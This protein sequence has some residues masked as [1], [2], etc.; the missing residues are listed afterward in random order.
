VEAVPVAD[1]EPEMILHRSAEHLAFGIVEAERE[2]VVTFRPFE[3]D[4]F[5]LDENAIGRWFVKH[6]LV[7]E[8]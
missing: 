8:R 7:P 3:T 6:V 4:G 5:E 1:G 2:E